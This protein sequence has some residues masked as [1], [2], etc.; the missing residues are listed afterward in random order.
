MKSLLWIAAFTWVCVTAVGAAAGYRD[1]KQDMDNYRPPALVHRSSASTA[2]DAPRP[3]VFATDNQ[4][5]EIAR[6]RWAAMIGSPPALPG[7]REIPDGLLETVQAGATAVIQPG[8]SVRDDE[9][10]RAADERRSA[11]VMI[12]SSIR[13]SFA[14]F[15]VDWMMNMSSPRTFS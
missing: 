15:D 4:V 7:N 8:G 14:G 9:V 6:N 13:L 10:I 12:S 11:S 2:T 3:D 1:L 5:I